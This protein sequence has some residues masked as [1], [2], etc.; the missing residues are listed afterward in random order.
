MLR[1]LQDHP[2]FSS[3]DLLVGVETRDDA[4][5]YRLG[6]GRVLIQTVDFFTP[7]V[8]D[9]RDFGRIAAANALSDVYA[10]GGRP[11]TALQL[12][13]WP[14]ED[15]P[16]AVLE[17]I[18]R[19]GAEKMAEAGCTVVGGHTI[20]DAV[21]KYGFAVTGTASEGEIIANAG[22]RPGD[23]LVLTKPLGTGIITTAHKAGEC[24]PEVLKSAVDT[25]G[26]LNDGAARAMVAGGVSAA[27]DV[28]GYGLAGHLLSML[29]ASGAGAR[30]DSSRLPLLPGVGELL[31]AGHYPGGSLRNM[32][33]AAPRLRGGDDTTRR[34]ICDAQTSGGLL[35]AVRPEF[36]G[37]LTT[38]L[39]TEGTGAWVIGVVIDREPLIEVQE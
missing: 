6:D 31:A 30:V 8:D 39:G 9:P 15:L 38:R 18:A 34:L 13:C 28:T 16:L 23:R 19:G 32:A 10:M 36:L 26:S 22:A 37:A 11:L 17:E 33:A 4:G 2:A 3:P 24:P 12:M 7:V 27:T 1:P 35:I 14:S 20:E 29:K 5:V 25:M 21:P